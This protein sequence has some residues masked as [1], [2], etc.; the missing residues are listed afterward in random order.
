MIVLIPYS[1]MSS[2]SSVT[3]TIEIN[4]LF[5]RENTNLGARF[6]MHSELFQRIQ[7][8]DFRSNRLRIIQNK[9]M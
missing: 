9:C 3:V 1:E 2:S 5:L 6:I 8:L 4:V 7:W